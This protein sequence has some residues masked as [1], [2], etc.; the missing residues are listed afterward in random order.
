MYFLFRNCTIAVDEGDTIVLR[1]SN[2]KGG[3]NVPCAT[4]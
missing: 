4:L 1:G 3:A 2:L